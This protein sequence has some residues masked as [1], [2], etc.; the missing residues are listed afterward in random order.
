MQLF[1]TN[2]WHTQYNTIEKVFKNSGWYVARL[3]KWRLFFFFVCFYF[4]RL[5]DRIFLARSIRDAKQHRLSD[6]SCETNGT[7]TQHYPPSH[8]KLSSSTT[9]LFGRG[10]FRETL[11]RI[12]G[13]A[14][15]LFTLPRAAAMGYRAAPSRASLFLARYPPR[16]LKIFSCDLAPF[17]LRSSDKSGINSCGPSI[18]VRGPQVPA[19]VFALKLTGNHR[20][21]M[22]KTDE[23]R[24]TNLKHKYKRK[25]QK[26]VKKQS[27]S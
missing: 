17:L 3:A 25:T 7:N 12:G 10:Y 11:F 19:L 22:N 15:A 27:F 13:P 26:N 1:C 20:K 14:N 16:F 23:A 5:P 6:A 24:Q 9:L 8:R 18:P 4:P 21:N 2:D